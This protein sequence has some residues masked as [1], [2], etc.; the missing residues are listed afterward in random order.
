MSPFMRIDISFNDLIDKTG[1]YSRKLT[2]TQSTTIIKVLSISKEIIG[3]PSQ[4]QRSL[5]HKCMERHSCLM[6]PKFVAF[7]QNTLLYV[8]LSLLNVKTLLRYVVS[9]L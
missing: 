9:L 3:F 4:C 8:V 7:C 2:E 1:P 6:K 5:I